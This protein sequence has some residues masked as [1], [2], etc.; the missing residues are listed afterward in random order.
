ML[1]NRSFCAIYS[2]ASHLALK[3][4]ST[5]ALLAQSSTRPLTGLFS[6]LSKVDI[7]KILR[8]AVPR[9]FEAGRTITRTGEP[10]T[11]LFLIETGSVDYSKTTP[12]GR[13]VLLRRLSA[14]EAFGL[15]TLLDIPLGYIGT[16]QTVQ[17]SELYSWERQWMRR[18]AE[19]Y[20]TLPLNALRIA[21]ECIRLYSIRHLAL[22]SDNAGDR[23]SRALTGLAMRIG[24]PHPH[25]IEVPVTNEDLASLADV[26]YFT[27]SRLLGRWQRNGAVEK[28]RGKVVIHC[29]ERMQL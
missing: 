8:A 6:G 27:T 19:E 9:I 18:Y 1:V 13:E 28:G 3:R 7:D 26:G 16:A 25:G 2:V 5:S 10:A 15:G 14:G 24:K 21:L 11:H 17:K 22:V 12:E 23:V 20:P 4:T 29:P